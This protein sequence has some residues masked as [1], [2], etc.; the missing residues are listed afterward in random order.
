V[1]LLVIF[2]LGGEVLRGFIFAIL[3]GIVIGTYSSLFVAS[4][5]LYD[6]SKK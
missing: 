6:S 5:L 1:V 4:P 2:F 3:F